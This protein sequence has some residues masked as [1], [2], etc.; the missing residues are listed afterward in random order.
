MSD[1]LRIGIVGLGAMGQAHV[2]VWTKVAGARITAVC[3]AWPERANETAERLGVLPFMD[4][5]QMAASGEID[6]VDIATPSGLH[7]EQGL[8]AAEHGVH[9]LIE[10]P[11]DIDIVKADRL[12]ELCERKGLTLACIF[13]RRTYGGVQ[14]VARAIHEG[15]MGKILSCSAYVKWWRTQD[16]YDSA[17]WR[18]TRALDGGVLANQAIH[19]LDQICWYA[20]PVVEV[21]YAHLEIA[22]H[23]METEDYAIA[24]LR[25]E[26]GARGVIEATTCCSPDFGMRVEVFGTRGSAAFTEVELTHFGIDGEDM[27][28]T[29]PHEDGK[30]GGG[31]VP[32]AISLKGHELQF[33]DFVQAVRTGRKPMVSGRDARMS[34]DALCKI[35]AKAGF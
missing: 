31:S 12:I 5:G 15:R 30:I 9:C 27:I 19:V 13:Q 26:S 10:K 2:D 29:V 21:E 4:V 18:G 22:T 8:A 25:F 1:T 7:A 24:V 35:Y 6:A 17:G 16:Y 20:G 3:D 32:M 11:L 34:V 23:R 28:P 33:N 14:A